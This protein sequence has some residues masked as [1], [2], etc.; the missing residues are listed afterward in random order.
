MTEVLRTPEEAFSGL[1]D[2]PFEPNYFEWNGIRMHYLD[3][4]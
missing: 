1:P 2:Y 4:G 3:E